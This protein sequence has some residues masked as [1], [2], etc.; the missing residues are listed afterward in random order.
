MLFDVFSWWQSLHG[1]EQLFWAIGLISNSLFAVYLVIQF[2]GGGHEGDFDAGGDADAGLAILSVRSLLAFGMF[3][4]YTGVVALRLGAGWPVALLAGIVGGIIAAWLAWRLLRVVLR[5][6][7][8]GTLDLHNTIGQTGEVHLLI[9]ARQTGAGK[10]MVTVQGALREMDAVS[11]GGEIPTGESILVVGITDEDV[12]IVQPFQ[13]L[14]GN[15]KPL[16]MIT[17]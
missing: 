12:L 16:M 5:L 4:G 6:Q 3:M 14:P 8:S 13:A 11:E 2:H 1:A 9:P 17:A 7:S 10:V 15:K